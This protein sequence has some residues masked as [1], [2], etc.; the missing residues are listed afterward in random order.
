[1]VFE[2]LVVPKWELILGTVSVSEMPCHAVGAK[3]M[4]H[5]LVNHA[6]ADR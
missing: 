4:E 2:N 6:M 1:M 5:S 3:F